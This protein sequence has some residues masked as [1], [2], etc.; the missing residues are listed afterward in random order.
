MTTQL[1]ELLGITERAAADVISTATGMAGAL[2][3]MAAPGTQ[4]RALYEARPDLAH[5][6]VDVQPQLTRI[7]TALLIGLS[8]VTPERR[9]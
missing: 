1:R 5:G 7:L 4:L 3:Q 9:A 6:V 2:R 8:A